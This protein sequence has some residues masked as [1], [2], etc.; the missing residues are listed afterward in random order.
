MEERG[1][2]RYILKSGLRKRGVEPETRNHNNDEKSWE[3][4]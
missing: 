3:P 1:G 2:G 4:N